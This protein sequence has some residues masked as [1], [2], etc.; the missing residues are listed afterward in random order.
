MKFLSVYQQW[1]LRSRGCGTSKSAGAAH[2]LVYEP[3]LSRIPC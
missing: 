1:T 2:A 3:Y